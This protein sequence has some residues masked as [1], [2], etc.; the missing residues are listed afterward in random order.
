MKERS[1]VWAGMILVLGLVILASIASAEI[2]RVISYQGRISDGEGNPVTDGTYTMRFRIYDAATGG[3]LEWDSGVQSIVLDGGIFNVL[4]GDAG[5]PALD[6][7][8]AEEY[9]LVVTF[10]GVNQL[11][12]QRLTSVGY[13]YMASGLVPGTEIIGSVDAGYEA[14]IAG[15]NT[16]G[17]YGGFFQCDGT[18][19]TGVYGRATRTAGISRGVYGITDSPQGAGVVGE[20]TETTGN[21]FGVY[22]ITNSSSGT[23]V[24]GEANAITGNT[25]GIRGITNSSSGTGVYGIADGTTGNTYGVR[26]ETNSPNGKAVCGVAE[27]T[28][29]ET[30]G[31][32]GI[33]YSSDGTGVY[34]VADATTGN[35]V[36]GVYGVTSASSG[37]M[38]GVRGV[39]YSTEGRGVM[40]Q[41]WA[42]TGNTYGVYARAS[43]NSGTALFGEAN[44]N[45]GQN[46][47]VRAKT[48]SPDGYAGYFEGRGYFSGHVGIGT[49]SPDC[50]LEIN[51]DGTSWTGGFLM[52]KNTDEDAGLRLY[53]SDSSAKH[54][55][56]ND[57]AH[58]DR[59]R[60]APD[61][62]YNSGITVLQNGNVGVNN[63]NPLAKFAVGGIEGASGYATVIVNPSNG[64]FYYYSS[65]RNYK[66]DIRPLEVDFDRILD[67]EPKSFTDKVS[68][69]WNIGYIAEEFDDLGLRELVLYRDGRPDGLKYELV[70]IY[71]LEM[72][73]ELKV[74]N[75]GFRE[76]LNALKAAR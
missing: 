20:C 7:E 74:E 56:F 43:S 13:A 75:D 55:L 76:E 34:G 27:G 18:Y 52:L 17:S 8:F 3:N 37:L 69:Q 71:L 36:S 16:A 67:A 28:T 2:P 62:N 14:V 35:Y 53:D 11:P 72:I 38:I 15:I 31:I 64:C 60:I 48:N 33:T 46:Y 26:G 30:I 39:S 12:R 65:S 22:G 51:G 40:G 59:L 4:L 68:G 24:Y 61:G 70:S 6:M 45:N 21:N 73:K 42:N 58:G 29:G 9:W 47:G 32:Y 44:N 25:Y 49:T 10:D 19:G 5:Q 50:A 57:N 23:G 54:H 41:A 66:E 1:F 63:R